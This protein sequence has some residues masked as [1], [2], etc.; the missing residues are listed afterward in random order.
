M[1]I[2][3]TDG[4]MRPSP[5]QG[6]H[7]ML[8]LDR[9]LIMPAITGTLKDRLTQV[10]SSYRQEVR[11]LQE[12]YPDAV[13]SK[14]TLGQLMGGLRGVSSLLC[15]TSSVDPDRGLVV[16]G[17]PIGHLTEKPAEEVFYLLLTGELPDEDALAALR[18]ELRTRGKV[19][20]YVWNVLEALP[21][22]SHPMA[23][24]TT[25]ILSMERESEF[26]RRYD[27]GRK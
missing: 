24:L 23:M 15:D 16:R 22:D 14:V 8:A 11:S 19:P 21:H 26:R 6:A 2:A 9:G 12:K 18:V 13:V 3:I 10:I 7:A 20:D 5:D 25:A 27:A 4:W 1:G 17:I